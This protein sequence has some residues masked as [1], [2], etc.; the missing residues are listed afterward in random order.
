MKRYCGGNFGKK[1]G[2]REKNEGWGVFFFVE[3]LLKDE[4]KGGKK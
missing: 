2:R 1:E 3:N 4:E